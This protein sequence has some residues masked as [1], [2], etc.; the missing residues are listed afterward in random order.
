M[1]KFI[2]S[3]IAVASLVTTLAT[4]EQAQARH[5]YYQHRAYYSCHHDR[6]S[7]ANRGTL[8]GAIGGGILGNVVA[9]R[10]SKTGGTLIG[11]GVGAVAGHEIARNNHRC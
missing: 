9:G 10:H 1:R 6:R 11:A 2:G 7:A 4:P 5:R 3:A 8:I